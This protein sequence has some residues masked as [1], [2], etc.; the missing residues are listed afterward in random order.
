MFPGVQ[1]LERVG[2][3]G[4]H[5]SKLRFGVEDPRV[6]GRASSRPTSVRRLDLRPGGTD[7]HG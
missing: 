4:G 5:P 3:P 1:H 6:E 7:K 2:R